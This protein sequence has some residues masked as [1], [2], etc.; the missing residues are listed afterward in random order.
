MLM[1]VCVTG[2][3]LRCSTRIAN[4]VEDLIMEEKSLQNNDILISFS[5]LEIKL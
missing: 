1:F 4:G 5:F 2:V 3:Q